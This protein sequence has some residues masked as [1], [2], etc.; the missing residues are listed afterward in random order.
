MIITYDKKT[1]KELC[2]VLTKNRQYMTQTGKLAQHY[3]SDQIDLCPTWSWLSDTVYLVLINLTQFSFS[4]T[5]WPTC[6]AIQLLNL[7]NIHQIIL[8]L[9]ITQG[10]YNQFCEESCEVRN[11]VWTTV[12]FRTWWLLWSPIYGETFICRFR[13]EW[14]DFFCFLFFTGRAWFHDQLPML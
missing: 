8:S 2:S 1:V 11:L 6:F 5:L 12:A 4:Q 14:L 9:L 3:F 7:M 13:F 10:S